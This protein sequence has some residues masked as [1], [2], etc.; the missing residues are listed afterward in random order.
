MAAKVISSSGA[1]YYDT[2]NLEDVPPWIELLQKTRG[3]TDMMYTTWLNNYKLL[4]EFARLLVGS[5]TGG[6]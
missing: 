2:D 6:D 1:A 5:K 3:S 4:P